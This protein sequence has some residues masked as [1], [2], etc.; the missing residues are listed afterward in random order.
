MALN[1][2][3]L[4][5]ALS[6]DNFRTAVLLG[7]LRFAR[8]RAL[9]I[10]VVFGFF[11]GIAPLAGILAGNDISREIGDGLADHVGAAAL[12][13]YGLYLIVRALQTASQEQLRR[14]LNWSIFGLP[15][16]LSL[17]NLIAGTGVGMLGLSPL[18]PATVFGAITILMTLVGLQLG[19]VVTRFIPIRPRWDV[20]VGVALIIQALVLKVGV[21]P[22]AEGTVALSRAPDRG[23]QF[24]P[25]QP[26]RVH[27]R[28]P[29]PRSSGLYSPLQCVELSRLSGALLRW[30]IVDGRRLVG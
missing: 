25:A 3:V 10:A 16:P 6:L 18:V 29:G 5:F 13:L 15:V 9:E 7:P 2:I 1:L 26:G 11:D 28:A 24:R 22:T 23:H 21:L 20:V 8:I 12:S 14:E 27:R 30:S 19:R 4:G 17:D